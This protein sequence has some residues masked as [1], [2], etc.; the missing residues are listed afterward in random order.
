[1]NQLANFR[2]R[3]GVGGGSKVELER[4][5]GLS[6]GMNNTRLRSVIPR[7]LHIG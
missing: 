7:L 3:V 4:E 5:W 1:M 2:N 6:G